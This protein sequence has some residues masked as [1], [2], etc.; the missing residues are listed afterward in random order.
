MGKSFSIV[1]SSWGNKKRLSNFKIFTVEHNAARFFD[2]VCVALMRSGVFK[3][4]I[5]LIAAVENRQYL[6]AKNF[7]LA[8][9]PFCERLMPSASRE[10]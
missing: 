6:G 9:R 10:N 2:N 3:D 8:R 5:E 1:M 4:I 7:Y